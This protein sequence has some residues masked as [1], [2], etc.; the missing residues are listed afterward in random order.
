MRTDIVDGLLTLFYDGSD[1]LFN[2]KFHVEEA[3]LIV[4]PRTTNMTAEEMFDELSDECQ[5]Y[6]RERH[7]WEQV[8]IEEGVTNIPGRVFL[9]CRNIKRVIMA[10]TVISIGSCAFKL[11]RKLVFFKPSI[12]LKYIG[13]RAF[14]NCNLSSV[15]IPPSCQEV[16]PEAFAYNR[17]LTIF[18]V[19]EHT[20]L[21]WNFLHSTNLMKKSR[22]GAI[23]TGEYNLPYN[24]DD[25]LHANLH[26]EIQEWIRNCN[27]DE[28]YSLHRACSAVYPLKEDFYRIIDEKGLKAFK[29]KNA[30]GITPSQ[31]LRE[32]PFTDFSEIDILRLYFSKK[33][34]F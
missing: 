26:G 8:M 19:S 21:H 22:F 11:C 31:Y 25:A 23:T 9:E 10:D 5:Q 28:H 2:S 33:L 14:L 18:S 3:L 6:F 29:T 17:D 13:R 4:D 15:F 16:G 12:N 30:L 32:N 27:D 7:S 34:D 20:E 24:Y 1:K